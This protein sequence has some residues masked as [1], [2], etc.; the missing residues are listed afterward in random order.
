M[1]HAH[2][3][4]ATRTRRREDATPG[5]ERDDEARA[6]QGSGRIPSAVPGLVSRTMAPAESSRV[7]RRDFDFVGKG[8]FAEPI[9]FDAD[10]VQAIDRSRKF[11]VGIDTVEKAIKKLKTA[12]VKKAAADEIETFQAFIAAW[13]GVKV[14]LDK[15]AEVVKKI[16]D[17]TDRL[18]AMPEEYAQKDTEAIAAARL[19][20]E[21]RRKQEVERR[22]LEQEAAKKKQQEEDAA[23]EARKQRRAEQAAQKISDDRSALTAR[24]VLPDAEAAAKDQA[25]EDTALLRG[26]SDRESALAAKRGATKRQIEGAETLKGELAARVV[27][28]TNQSMGLL[29]DFARSPQGLALSEADLR[30]VIQ[31]AGPDIGRAQALVKV[32]NA[33]GV[34]RT[35]VAGFSGVANGAFDEVAGYC[36]TLFGKNVPPAQILAGAIAMAEDDTIKAYLNT[37][38]GAVATNYLKLPTGGPHALKVALV[39]TL[40]TQPSSS[41]YTEQVARQLFDGLKAKTV[42]PQTIAWLISRS[43]TPEFSGLVA[44]CIE[45]AIDVDELRGAFAASGYTAAETLGLLQRHKAALAALT[46]MIADAQAGCPSYTDLRMQ[47][48]SLAA[49]SEPQ[50]KA[51]LRAEALLAAGMAGV[52][53]TMFQGPRDYGR[54]A[55]NTHQANNIA[56][57]AKTGFARLTFTAPAQTHEVHT[58]WFQADGKGVITSMHVVTAGDNG[59]EIQT[60]SETPTLVARVVAAHN[61]D[62][63]YIKPG[64]HDFA[65]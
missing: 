47:Y 15:R 6:K 38:A 58:H 7:I 9:N 21:E 39:A 1:T 53:I 59:I 50:Q 41:A 44:L 54:G 10:V 35:V 61:G 42:T 45:K 5:V 24:N 46:G 57:D 4:E 62:P 55:D 13:N 64:G 32:I 19:E 51:A 30:L 23:E 11:A 60:R 20:A 3:A 49:F 40:H 25:D 14:P 16:A 52:S 48:R 31:T 22:R 63:R 17:I 56:R 37:A 34:D 18:S 2:V 28:S 65:V 36:I 29:A 12:S 27:E 8:I 33:S 43:A 26:A